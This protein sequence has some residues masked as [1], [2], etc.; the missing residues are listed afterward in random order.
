MIAAICVI[1]AR[2]FGFTDLMNTEGSLLYLIKSMGSGLLGTLMVPV[3]SAYMAYSIG[4]KPALASGFAAGFVLIPL[5]VDSYSGC[6]VGSLLGYSIRYFKERI[7]AKGTF[8]GFVSFVIYPVLSCLIVGVLLL[9]VLGKPVAMINTAL[10]DFLGSMAGTNAALLGAVLG[11]MVSFDLGGPVNKAAYA[12][13]VGCNGRKE[14]Y[15]HIVLLLQLK[16]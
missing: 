7:P 3:L 5:A 8:A 10:V 16:C 4:D 6:L 13:C 12:F 9:V 2:T 14:F 11:I 15:G 1:F